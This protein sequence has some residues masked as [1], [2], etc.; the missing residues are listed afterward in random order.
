MEGR[1]ALFIPSFGSY[2]VEFIVR[3]CTA[4]EFNGMRCL[5]L[6]TCEDYA[7]A[8]PFPTSLMGYDVTVLVSGVCFRTAIQAY[9]ISLYLMYLCRNIVIIQGVPETSRIIYRKQK[10]KRFF[11]DVLQIYLNAMRLYQKLIIAF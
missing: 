10:E 4:P 7:E 3:E 11:L 8:A 6:G 2:W 1:P 9:V 5:I